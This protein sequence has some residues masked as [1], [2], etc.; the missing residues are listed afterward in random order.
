[1][2]KQKGVWNSW[3]K[4]MIEELT[5]GIILWESLPRPSGPSH[6]WIQWI[7]LAAFPREHPKT[8]RT[9]RRSCMVWLL[10][11]PWRSWKFGA[12]ACTKKRP[13]NWKLKLE[14]SLLRE[15]KMAVFKGW[16]IDLEEAATKLTKP[17]PLKPYPPHLHHVLT[18]CHSCQGWG[19]SGRDTP[20]KDIQKDKWKK[21]KSV[22]S[23]VQSPNQLVNTIESPV[24][25][26]QK[27]SADWL[28]PIMPSILVKPQKLHLSQSSWYP[29]CFFLAP[30]PCSQTCQTS[31]HLTAM[32]A[33]RQAVGRM[34]WMNWMFH[35]KFLATCHGKHSASFPPGFSSWVQGPVLQQMQRHVESFSSHPLPGFTIGG[36]RTY[37]QHP[38]RAHSELSAQQIGFLPEKTAARNKLRHFLEK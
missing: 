28:Y 5:H 16:M 3:T 31:N 9:T 29:R 18:R 24:I 23:I 22:P 4:L 26:V 19:T 7:P 1:M 20:A 6:S 10:I 2:E 13:R 21:F 37:L 25:F 14:F 11:S 27:K 32:P 30:D 8:K 38:C 35:P 12:L 36:I 17:S 34:Y 33:I 15:K